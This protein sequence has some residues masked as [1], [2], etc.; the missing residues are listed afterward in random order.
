MRRTVSSASRTNHRSR[1]AL[2]MFRGGCW[3]PIPLAKA[4]TRQHLLGSR[5][6]ALNPS[7]LCLYR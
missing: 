6:V 1:V 5:R 3:L 2:A 7:D 4:E